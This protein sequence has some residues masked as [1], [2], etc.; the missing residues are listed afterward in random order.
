MTA[1]IQYGTQDGWLEDLNFGED[2]SAWFAAVGLWA[3]AVYDYADGRVSWGISGPDEAGGD[4][5]VAGTAGSVAEAMRAATAE[6]RRLWSA[7]G[8]VLARLE[9][10][11]S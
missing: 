6:V 4:L 8:E 1:G 10:V 7:Q 2:C 9:Q 5:D 11:S 3:L